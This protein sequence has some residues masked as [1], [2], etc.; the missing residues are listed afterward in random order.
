MSRDPLRPNQEATRVLNE[1]LDVFGKTGCGPALR[2]VPRPVSLDLFDAAA[3]RA[4]LDDPDLARSAARSGILF[5]SPSFR[6][7]F[8]CGAVVTVLQSKGGTVVGFCDDHADQ[9]R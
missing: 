4:A 5:P 6:C 3:E 2:F 7:A 1:T 9:I 8:G